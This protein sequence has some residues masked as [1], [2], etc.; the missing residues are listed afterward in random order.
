M[1]GIV[2]HRSESQGPG[3]LACGS[4]LLWFW[5][6]YRFTSLEC[7]SLSWSQLVDNEGKNNQLPVEGDK[8]WTPE[9][10]GRTDANGQELEYTQRVDDLYMKGCRDETFCKVGAKYEPNGKAIP[11][12]TVA[13]WM[14]EYNENGLA[15]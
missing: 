6:Y 7:D 4:M 14:A 12:D 15:H 9:I 11:G 10:Q 13:G 3:Y 1:I 2:M 5:G 8:H